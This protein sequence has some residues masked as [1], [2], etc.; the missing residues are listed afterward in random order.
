MMD[1]DL[2]VDALLAEASG[3]RVD[4]SPALTARI[5]S[6]AATAQPQPLRAAGQR[7]R[8][9][10]AGLWTWPAGRASGRAYGGAYGGAYGL[11][12]DLGG[13]GALAGLSLA[14]LTGLFLGVANPTA[15]QTLTTLISGQAVQVDQMDLL[16]ATDTLWTEN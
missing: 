5:L 9:K 11:A 15:L 14:G 10:T 2:D 7:P 13:I 6:D 8:R 12:A 16:P 4:P 1:E 3:L